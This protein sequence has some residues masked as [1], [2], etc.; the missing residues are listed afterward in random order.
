[1]IDCQRKTYY[2]QL[3]YEEAKIGMC[4]V[5][6]TRMDK[7]MLERSKRFCRALEVL[8]TSGINHCDMDTYGQCRHC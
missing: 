5:A 8:N 6:F 4:W 3:R 1:M 7:L 2:E